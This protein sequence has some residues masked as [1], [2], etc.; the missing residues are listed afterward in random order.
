MSDNT[1]TLSVVSP[2]RSLVNEIPVIAVGAK[3]SEGDFT[4]LPGH[5]PFLTDL[6]PANMWYRAP[7]RTQREIFV[8]GGFVEV[9]PTKVTV[10]A[11]SAEYT[12][13]IDPDRAQRAIQRRQN[14]QNVLK[15]ML[16]KGEISVA[17]GEVELRKV[18]AKLNRSMARL[19]AAR[20]NR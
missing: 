4:A 9:L 20:K 11:D 14:R 8:S 10:L 5:V 18:E 17:Q 7:D 16:A 2:D 3:G 13:E 15:A 12:D 1:F 19:K 6:K